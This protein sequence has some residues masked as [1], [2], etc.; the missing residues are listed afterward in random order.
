MAIAQM[1]K[2]TLIALKKDSE[3]ILKALQRIGAVHITQSD[4]EGQ[5]VCVE[6]G[7][8]SEIEQKLVEVRNAISFL[9]KYDT[10]KKSL[11]SA[12]PAITFEQLTD[13]LNDEGKMRAILSATKSIEERLVSL[14]SEKA[15]IQNRINAIKPYLQFDAPLETVRPT[16]STRAYLGMVNANA[17]MIL[18]EIE[19]KYQG[20][21]YMERLDTYM[22]YLSVF[23]VAHESIAAD[24]M[25]DL[26][27]AYFSEF[28]AAEYQGLPSDVVKSLENDIFKAEEAM[29][30]TEKET[31]ALITEL[32]ALKALEDYYA[33]D[34]ERAKAQDLLSGTAKTFHME[35]WVI[36]GNEKI[37]EDTVLKLTE[38]YYIDFRDPYEDEPF[39]VALLNNRILRPFEAV[40]EMYSLPD[41]RG[42]DPTVLL[43]PFYFIFY[44]MMVSDAGYGI[45]LTIFALL[46]LKIQKPGG[47]FRKILGIISM[48]GISTLIWGS[49]YGGWFGFSLPPLWFNPMDNP[50]MMLILV[51]ALG[52]VHVLTGLIIG[53]VLLFKKGQWVDAF[54]DK[55]I[56]MIFIIGLPM[57]AFGGMLATIGGYMAIFGTAGIILTNGRGKKGILKKLMGGLAALYGS[58]GYLSDV[59]SYSRLFGMG[60]ATGVI[61]MV[62]NTIAGMMTGSIIGWIAAAVIFL[63]GHT[64]NIGINALGAYVHSCRLMYI[65]YFSKFYEDGGKPYKPLAYKIKNYRMEN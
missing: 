3:A 24:A 49:L 30:E 12:K 13:I 35:G 42:V 38:L 10:S 59:L 40:I 57:M 2:L 23:V 4:T 34:L 14:R 62:F 5:T 46:M 52:F 16:Q 18:S 43:A 11:F 15:R 22:E 47:M 21:I 54:C 60:L 25:N 48:T 45:V 63:V 9:G 32:L 31:E 26:K 65:E 44:G 37:V 51:L 6:S 1:K 8:P 58:T 33:T 41:P 29:I 55:I 61:A 28:S 20:L 19:E 27:A 64:F 39:P 53:A 50:M 36:V 17:E 56:W 7:L